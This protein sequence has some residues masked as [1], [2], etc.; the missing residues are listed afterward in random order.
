MKLI[1]QLLRGAP[2]AADVIAGRRGGVCELR[3]ANRQIG[4]AERRRV[5]RGRLRM[6]RMLMLRLRLV[7]LLRVRMRMRMRQRV[8]RRGRRIQIASATNDSTHARA[9]A[10]AH[11]AAVEHIHRFDIER[12]ETAQ[13]RRSHLFGGRR[14]LGAFGG[15]RALQV[16]NLERHL[17]GAERMIKNEWK[18]ERRV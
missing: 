2:Q 11:T 5:L 16:D 4:R 15:E 8:S 6:L 10:R 12:E 18:F 3:E 14:G 17:S 9:R 13:Q 7:K 1:V